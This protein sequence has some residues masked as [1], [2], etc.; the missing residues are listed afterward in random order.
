M[1][2]VVTAFLVAFGLIVVYLVIQ[3]KKAG[4]RQLDDMDLARAITVVN[5]AYCWP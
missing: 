1:P 5:P 3:S 2:P 4:P